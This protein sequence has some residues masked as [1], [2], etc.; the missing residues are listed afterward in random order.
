MELS[1][2]LA[3]KI[4]GTTGLNQ[5][6]PARFAGRQMG[7]FV[8]VEI[9]THLSRASVCINGTNLS[10]G[11]KRH[12]EDLLSSQF[13]VT[14]YTILYEGS[15]IL[16]LIPENKHWIETFHGVIDTIISHL[17][18][19]PAVAVTDESAGDKFPYLPSAAYEDDITPKPNYAMGF[20]GAILGAV[21]GAIIWFIVS[22]L[23]PGDFLVR[24][25][26]L[27]N[28]MSPR[29]LLSIIITCG[30]YWGFLLL[31][32][33]SRKM[34]GLCSA[35]ITFGMIY[36]INRF[37][38]AFTF[39]SALPKLSVFDAF[40]QNT[41]L[42]QEYQLTTYYLLALLLACILSILTYIVIYLMREKGWKR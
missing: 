31:S 29:F 4:I 13:P 9:Q 3:K 39:Y 25:P 36:G 22:I 32:E 23:S 12:L 7:Y 16:L 14:D 15:E 37:S 11:D 35:P 5:I 21:P 42:L 40:I 30:S 33:A 41:D 18:G 19:S 6:E 24:T 20:F 34:S 10:E 17:S 1:S 26:E 8:T 38:Y 27:Q 28:S 2:D